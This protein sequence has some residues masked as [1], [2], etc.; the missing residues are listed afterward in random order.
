MLK[1]NIIEM[2][3]WVVLILTMVSAFG[4]L[5]LGAIALCFHTVMSPEALFGAGCILTL[6]S[7][8]I[9][10]SKEYIS[11]LAK[12]RE[13][14]KMLAICV[15]CAISLILFW[16]GLNCKNITVNPELKKANA[17]KAEM[18][19]AYGEYQ[20]AV[21]NMLD[22]VMSTDDWYDYH[23][24]T[25]YGQAYLDASAKVDSLLRECQ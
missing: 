15:C 1:K 8:W 21:E 9:I 2:S 4:G 16:L 3:K 14:L 5:M 25:E 19:E 24:E 10:F 7:T 20:D 17:F 11:G 23:S 18:L 13:P 12:E 6:A 22:T